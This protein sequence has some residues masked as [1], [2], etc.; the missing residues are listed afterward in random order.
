MAM[1]RVGP[2]WRLPRSDVE[3]GQPIANTPR[4]IIV[5]ETP[6]LSLALPSGRGGTRFK[7]VDTLQVQLLAGRSFRLDLKTAHDLVEGP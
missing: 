6:A 4:R 3:A 7:V 1:M 2:M 5:S